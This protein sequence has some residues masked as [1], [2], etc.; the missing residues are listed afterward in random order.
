MAKTRIKPNSGGIKDVLTSSAMQAAVQE[1]ADEIASRAKASAPVDS[2][3]YRNSIDTEAGASTDRAVV[4]VV[5]GAEHSL[6]V[7]AKTGNLLRAASGGGD[8]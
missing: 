1:A 3:E 2:G 4:Y 7:E 5:A 8:G 6:V